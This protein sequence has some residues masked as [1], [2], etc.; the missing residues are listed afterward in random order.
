MSRSSLMIDLD[1]PRT[2]K[3]ADVMANATCKK[4]LSLL[5]ERELS[6]SEL[7]VE[8]R[9][10]LNTINY[11]MKKLVAA[12]LVEQVRS[13]LSVKGR[14]VKVYRVSQKNIVISPRTL[15]KGVLPAF[16]VALVATLG[17]KI[18]S[19]SPSD[20][21]MA[22]FAAEKSGDV[23]MVAAQT[24]NS[25]LWMWFLGGALVALVALSVWNWFFR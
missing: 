12:G 5:A 9:S 15:T 22:A 10:P 21:S 20:A 6:E 16:I 13:L 17:V 24:A 14:A 3:I 7:A 11:N 8:L 19:S 4:I 25:P 18:Y 2:R 23:A 1:D